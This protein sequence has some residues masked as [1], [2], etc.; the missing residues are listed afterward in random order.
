MSFVKYAVILFISLYSTLGAQSIITLNELKTYSEYGSTRVTSIVKDTVGNIFIT[1]TVDSTYTSPCA[2]YR[3]NENLEVDWVI[4]IG[5]GELSTHSS[6]LVPDQHGG[7]YFSHSF[8]EPGTNLKL[9]RIDS[10]GTL[11][12][13]KVIYS[14]GYE[15]AMCLALRPDN[16]IVISVKM[17][18]PN[19][20]FGADSLFYL[21]APYASQPD[22][23]EVMDILIVAE[24]D[25]ATGE[26]VHSS[27]PLNTLYNGIL[28]DFH[29]IFPLSNG[30]YVVI[31]N[32]HY[33]NENHPGYL[34]NGNSGQVYMRFSEDHELLSTVC[35]DDY[36]LLTDIEMIYGISYPFI[37]SDTLYWRTWVSGGSANSMVKLHLQT[38]VIEVNPIEFTAPWPIGFLNEQE[39]SIIAFTG[40]SA[41]NCNGVGL[42]IQNSDFSPLL[43][44][45]YPGDGLGIYNPISL[46]DSTLLA[47]YSR[48][49]NGIVSFSLNSS[50]HGQLFFDGNN[51]GIQDTNEFL[52]H[53]GTIDITNDSNLTWQ[54][55]A[56]NGTYNAAVGA[57]TFTLHPQSIPE[58]ECFP[59]YDTVQVANSYLE[60]IER[61]FAC[62]VIT[63]FSDL[64]VLLIPDILVAG[65]PFQL[66]VIVKNAGSIAEGCILSIPIPETLQLINS[67]VQYSIDSDVFQCNLGVLQAFESREI[68]LN[69]T[70]SAPPDLMPSEIVELNA[71]CN[72]PI[73]D[74]HPENNTFQCLLNVLAAYDPNDIQHI[75]GNLISENSV[76]ASEPFVY[77]IRF[78]NEGN[79]ETSFIHVRDTLGTDFIQTSVNTLASSHYP[80]N[81]SVN[82][83]GVIDWFFPSIQLLPSSENEEQSKGWILFEVVP[84]NTLTNGMYVANNANIYF[85]FNSAIITNTDTTFIGSLGG[86]ASIVIPKI[87]LSPNP[88]DEIVEIKW[89][90]TLKGPGEITIW[91]IEGKILNTFQVKEGLHS[92]RIPTDQLTSGLYFVSFKCE[93][94]IEQ[95]VSKLIV[96]H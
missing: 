55:S 95:I 48:E 43:T 54:E 50:I 11:V 28:G 92:R 68:T 89:G 24:L 94:A 58:L 35:L 20:T 10:T 37:R 78:Q 86:L 26:I 23:L 14:P 6:Q 70:S 49:V 22:N 72:M 12:W 1:R 5:L 53:S 38:G 42:Q 40:I 64:R 47:I 66:R 69:F 32:V 8:P 30:E 15:R 9:N 33:Q 88:A 34:C 63:P 4:N 21:Y 91:G 65:F 85:D 74:V 41:F 29:P 96:V 81:L 25:P 82:Q 57:G 87:T 83:E 76:V 44:Y 60:Y 7:C 17:G 71:F 13:E 45:C 46:N 75:R 19:G 2:I 51:N 16:S 80:V 52:V 93:G 36:Q 18:T 27:A 77:L 39:G 62:K 67:T 59:I 61:D 73:S 84:V 56:I 3:L 90:Q 79:Y 31:A